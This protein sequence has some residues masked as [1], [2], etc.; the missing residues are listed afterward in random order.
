MEWHNRVEF[1]KV[2]LERAQ[3]FLD[4]AI[5]NIDEGHYLTAANRAYY[6][7]YSAIRALLILEHTENFKEVSN[8]VYNKKAYLRTALYNSVFE[9]EAHF[10]NGSDSF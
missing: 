5:V 6:A 2:R 10:A 7:V 4:A 3:E 1:S 9:I 8:R